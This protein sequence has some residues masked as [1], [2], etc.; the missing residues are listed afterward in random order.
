MFRFS[1]FTKRPNWV[2]KQNLIPE[3][4]YLLASGAQPLTSAPNANVCILDVLFTQSERQDWVAHIDP[5]LPS[6]F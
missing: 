4:I 3:L 6:V 2:M 5:G 1:I